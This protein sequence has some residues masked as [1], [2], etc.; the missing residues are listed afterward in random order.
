M[1]GKKKMKLLIILALALLLALIAI[2]TL[3]A[4]EIPKQPLDEAFDRTV[5]IPYD[6]YDKVFVNGRKTNIYGEYKLYQRNDRVLVPVRLMGQL[7]S[8]LDEGNSYWD[9]IWEAKRPDDVLLVNHKLNKT[10]KLKV[11]NKTM[12]I[13]NQPKTIDVPPQ[14][15]KGRVVLP[16]RAIAEALGKKIE[17]LNGLVIISNDYIDLHSPKTLGIVDDIKDKLRDKR[18]EI[19]AERMVLPVGKYGDTTYYLKESFASN[20]YMLNLYKKVGNGPGV[21]IDLPGEEDL[22]NR[23]VVDNNLYYAS[24]V[25]GKS[26]LYRYNLLGGQKEKICSLGQWSPNDGWLGQVKYLDEQL[27]VVLHSG[28][29]TMGYDTLY[30]VEDGGLKEVAGGKNLM[31][32]ESQKNDFYY[33]DFRFM[34]D[35]TNNLYKVDLT[36]GEKENLGEPEFTYGIFRKVEEAGAI[37]YSSGGAIKLVDDFI[38]TL[39]YKDNDLEDKPA[40]YKVSISDPSHRKLTPP[41]KNFWLVDKEI[42]Y[43]DLAT[44]YLIKT[45]L[46]GHKQEILVEQPVNAAEIAAGSIYYTV[47]TSNSDFTLGKLYKYDLSTGRAVQLS[48]QSV[49]EFFVGKADIYYISEGY[50]LGLY[51]VGADGKST[52]LVDDTIGFIEVTAD[53]LVYTLRYKEGIYTAR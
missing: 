22:Y 26:E 42:Y 36:T 2:S 40:V 49:S 48:E 19:E 14:N 17:W 44:S 11:N 50:D 20:K 41:A 45:D 25:D 15:I 18:Q 28:D 47:Q 16:L 10:V 29:L 6:Y 13:N 46:E 12:H 5:I 21:K 51:K 9:V 39:G 4:V 27:Y 8:Y 33:V 1:E 52:C 7:A 30:K 43:I 23:N 31:Y 34:A 37:G 53:G 32:W 38:Y 35:P 24:V 3:G